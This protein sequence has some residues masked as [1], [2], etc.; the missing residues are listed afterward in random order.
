[1]S[2]SAAE[3]LRVTGLGLRSRRPCRALRVTRGPF[4]L[5]PAADAA[6]HFSPRFCPP[7]PNLEPKARTWRAYLTDVGRSFLSEGEGY[8]KVG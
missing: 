4:V 7:P 5:P 6:D 3:L 2:Y 8:S 1:M